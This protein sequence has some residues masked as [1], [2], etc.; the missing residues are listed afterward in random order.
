M[1]GK[2]FYYR[3]ITYGPYSTTS[4]VD[5]SEWYRHTTNTNP[6]IDQC[7]GNVIGAYHQMVESVRMEKLKAAYE[8]FKQKRPMAAGLLETLFGEA[9]FK[10]FRDFPDD[11]SET[12]AADLLKILNPIT[13]EDGL[14]RALVAISNHIEDE[15]A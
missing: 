2:D 7:E 1:K 5:L 14:D 11:L 13:L 6:T 8:E 3:K 4:T 15:I 9:A 10:V 12:R